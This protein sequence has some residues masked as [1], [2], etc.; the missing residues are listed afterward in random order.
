MHVQIR[1]I[2]NSQG[3]IIPRPLLQ[4][5]GAENEINLEVVEGAIVLRAVESNP[6]ANWDKLFQEAIANGHEP[7]N[8]L[9]NDTPND[10]DETEWQW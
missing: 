2:G 8:D 5:I 10:F 1:R 7:D 6:R 3:I 4:Q 9:F